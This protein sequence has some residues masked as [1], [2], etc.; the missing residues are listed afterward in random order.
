ME[1]DRQDLMN[2]GF[3]DTPL[4]E[5]PAAITGTCFYQENLDPDKAVTEIDIFPSDIVCTFIR[6]NMSNVKKHA[7]M[8]YVDCQADT[9]MVQDDMEDWHTDESGNPTEPTAKQKFIDK[10]LSIDP[11]DIVKSDTPVTSEA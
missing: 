5:F 4:A 2:Q 10:G 9:I 8:T 3:I 11:N 7:G 6:C 1:F